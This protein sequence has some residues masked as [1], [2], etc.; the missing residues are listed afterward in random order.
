MI[1]LNEEYQ[2]KLN[3]IKKEYKNTNMLFEIYLENYHNNYIYIRLDYF[4]KEHVHKLSWVDL[5]YYDGASTIGYEFIEDSEVNYLSNIASSR[6]LKETTEDKK[7]SNEFLVNVTCNLDHKFDMTFYRYID[8]NDRKLIDMLSVIF[9]SLP[10]KLN[11][12]FQEMAS[13]FTGNNQK[14]EYNDEISFD[15]FEDSLYDIFTEEI[16][17]RGEDYFQKGRVFFL[18]K[19]KDRYFAIVGGKSL[20]VVIIKYEEKSKRMQVCCSCPCDFRCKHIAAVIMAIRENKFHKFY[21]ITKKDEDANLLE[22]IM[23]LNFL[24]TIGIDDQG[25]NYLIIE[26]G[27]LKLLPVSDEWII[28]EDDSSETLTKRLKEILKLEDIK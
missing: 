16:I 19:I 13:L 11:V 15:L 1:T 21:K 25:K 5:N 23:N 2:N 10:L 17:D 22:R 18:E 24:L 26:D 7:D 12:F 27:L 28:L 4:K 8:K 20:Y 9:N 14:Y 6:E 3:K